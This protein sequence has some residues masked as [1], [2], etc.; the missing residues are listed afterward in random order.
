MKKK[1]QIEKAV[2]QLENQIA[3]VRADADAR[4]LGLKQAIA[5]LQAQK[6][7]ARKAKALS[8]AEI[9]AFV[10]APR[11]GKLAAAGA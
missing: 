11:D 3:S 7:P 4:I 9:Q 2:E 10:S 5:A 6:K 8:A 1:T